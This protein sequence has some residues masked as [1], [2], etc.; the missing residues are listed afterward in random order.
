MVLAA[1]PGRAQEGS[2]GRYAFRADSTLLR[3]TLD[4]H[5]PRLFPLSDS[6]EIPADTLRALS[7]RYLWS[8]ERLVFLADSLGVPVDSVG[9]FLA[10][11]R[12]NP[13]SASNGR[14]T[15]FSYNSAYT[16]GLDQSGWRNTADYGFR[17]GPVFVQNSTTVQMDRSG[18][19]SSLYQTRLSAT[20]VGWRF[21]PD[22]SLGSRVNLERLDNRYPTTSL[23]T[24]KNEYQLSMRSKQAPAPGLTSTFNFNGGLLDVHQRNDDKQGLS[25]SLNSRIRYGIGSWL[26][27]EV[28]A[29]LDGNLSRLHSLLVDTT[30]SDNSQ[31]VRGSLALF[32]SSRIGLKGNFNYRHVQ[33][34]T[35]NDTG[36]IERRLSDGSGVDGTLRLRQDNDRYVD[37]TQKLSVSK[38]SPPRG[39]GARNTRRDDGFNM[40]ARYLLWGWSLDARFA[41]SFTD[42]KFPSVTDSG[43][44]SQLLHSRSL[45][46]T[47]NRQLTRRINLQLSAAIS[48]AST[49]SSSIGK[50]PTPNIKDDWRQSWR[51]KGSY[52]PSGR[53]NTSLA[54]DVSKTREINL[55]STSTGTN[56]DRRSYRSDWNWTYRLLPGLTAVQTNSLSAAYTEYTFFV[57]NNRLNMEFASVTTLNAVVTPR[58]SISV[59]HNTRRAPSGNYTLYPDD[60]YYFQRSDEDRTASLR[61]AID[62]SPSPAIQL[63]FRPAYFATDG[64]SAL[65]GVEVPKSARR[66]LDF[67]G[68]ASIN[69]AI[70]SK[71]ALRGD[72]SRTYHA[73][74]TTSYAS[75][76]PQLS[77]STPYGYWNGSLQLSWHL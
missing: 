33:V 45:D 26:S 59:T 1:L 7:V 10:R 27:Q 66:A 31:N 18:S 69:Y 28:N 49:R 53:F 40:A 4:L 72:I 16:V 47:L 65:N 50:Y 54:L 12:F 11:E 22:F 48:L 76:V 34:E 13:L 61:A 15:D 2:G 74:R 77:P 39:R 41:N 73:D 71:G 55:L 51:A 52:N 56:N 25:G 38:L 62:Y 35:V 6:L 14:K 63:F 20:E 3:D 46:G 36:V 24:S 21:S 17:T 68:G 19:G 30:T 29:T 75:G 42:S 43:G 67:S 37:L 8:L 5:F 23:S 64:S 32:Q 70:G 58:L 60:L 44:Y 9:P 57:E